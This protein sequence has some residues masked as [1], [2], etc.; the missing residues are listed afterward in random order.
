MGCVK[1]IFN[2]DI[3][4]YDLHYTS[5]HILKTVTLNKIFA[6]ALYIECVLNLFNCVNMC[7]D[8]ATCN[9][10]FGNIPKYS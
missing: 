5:P 8:I 6:C 9:Y 4:M 1:H 7:A 2:N 10:F 3:V